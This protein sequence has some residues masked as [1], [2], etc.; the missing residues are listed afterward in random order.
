MNLDPPKTF[1]FGENEFV[2]LSYLEKIFSISRLIARKYLRALRIQPLYIKKEIYFSL[3][4]FN[5]LMFVLSRP[6]AKGFI[7]PGSTAKANKSLREQGFLIEVTD[8]IL[9][10]AA[11]PQILA[12]M[13]AA[14]GRD[15]SMVKKLLTHP[16]G[17][18]IYKDKPQEKK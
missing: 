11:S 12:E 8:D 1:V 13:I 7:F 6:G 17:T 18:I 10:E 2:E 15:T 4:T 14:S 9:K 5:R 16:P 3:P